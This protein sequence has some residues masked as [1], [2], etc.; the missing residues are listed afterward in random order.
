[1]R[2]AKQP[3]LIDIRIVPWANEDS[4]LELLRRAN[5]PEMTEHLGGPE[6]EDQL[7]ARHERYLKVNETGTGRMFS[8]ALLPD[9]ETVG[10]IGYWETLHHGATAY[11]MGWNVLPQYQGRGIAV[12][13]AAAAIA[14]ARSERKHAVVY[15]FPSIDHPASNAICKKSGFSLIG[16]CEF[17]YP[18]GNW[19]RCNE[20]RL[21]LDAIIRE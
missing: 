18:K 9:L 2:V 20:W 15:A 17:E 4:N 13:A 8:I 14:S 5:A 11:E 10:G 6:S 1:M 19:M 12:A 3:E 21:D 16:E 7:V